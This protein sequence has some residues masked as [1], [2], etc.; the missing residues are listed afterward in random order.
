[1]RRFSFIFFPL[2]DIFL[3]ACGKLEG[4]RIVRTAIQDIQALQGRPCEWCRVW[5]VPYQPG[6]WIPV[7]DWRE[8]FEHV[9]HPQDVKIRIKLSEVVPG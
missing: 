8:V 3:G 4:E 5:P 7:Q 6:D 2:A 1:M 9:L